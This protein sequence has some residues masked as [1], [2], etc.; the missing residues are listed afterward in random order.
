MGAFA[1]DGL[2]DPKGSQNQNLQKV[3]HIVQRQIATKKGSIPFL[4]TETPEELWGLCSG[5]AN[6]ILQ[7]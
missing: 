2:V 1:S 6:A 7:R 4:S 3:K 5:A